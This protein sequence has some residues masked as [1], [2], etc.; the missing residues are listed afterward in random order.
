MEEV[1]V[2]NAHVG[3]TVFELVDTVQVPFV[4][5]VDSLDVAHVGKW[6]VDFR[7]LGV[8]VWLVKVPGVVHEGGT[9]STVKDDW[10][11]AT[12]EDGNGTSTTGWAGTSALVHSDVSGNDNSPFLALLNVSRLKLFRLSVNLTNK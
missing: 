8:E 7:V 10:S 4:T 2:G 6:A 11:I 1:V 9:E 12:E 3:L 5:L